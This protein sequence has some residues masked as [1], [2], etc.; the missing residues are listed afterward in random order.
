MKIK[1]KKLPSQNMAYGGRIF[2]QVAPNALPDHTDKK[3]LKVNSTLQPVPEKEANIEAER[4]ETAVIP[5]EGGLPAHYKIGGKR[6]SQGGTPLNVPE[7]TFIFSDTKSMTIRDKDLLK[8]FGETKPK[9]PADIAKKYDINEYRKTLADPDS[10]NYERDTAE[11]MI[12]K[13]N[14]LLGKLALV[15]E[16]KKGFPQGIPA[17]ALPYVAVNNIDPQMILPSPPANMG[18]GQQQAPQEMPMAKYG[19][20]Q[21][22]RIKS[23]P[24][25][26]YGVTV[27]Q[28][29]DPN[30]RFFDYD[31]AGAYTGQSLPA[32]Y[33]QPAAQTQQ[34]PP[35]KSSPS[36]QDLI[37]YDRDF[38]DEYNKLNKE[39]KIVADIPQVN[40]NTADARARNAKQKAINSENIY[41]DLDWSSDDLYQDFQRRHKWYLEQ[42]PD[43]D[44][45]NKED[46]ADFQTKYCQRASSFGMKGCHFKPSGGSGTGVDGKFGEHTWAAPGFNTPGE[47]PATQQPLP[48]A[49]EKQK[50]I[51]TEPLSGTTA[52]ETN[53]EYF[54]QDIANLATAMSA[55]IPKPKTFYQPLLFRG[56]DPAY[57]T[58]DYSPIMEAANQAITGIGAYGSRQ[59]ADASISKIQGESARQAADHNLQVS[60]TN[61][62]IYNNAEQFNAQ[63]A[64]ANSQYNAQKKEMNFDTM[65]AYKADI[66]KAKNKKRAD[67]VNMANNMLT[68]AVGAYNLNTLYPHYQISPSSGGKAIFDRGDVIKANKNANASELK[69]LDQELKDLGYTREERLEIMK[70]AAGAKYKAKD[71]SYLPDYSAMAYPS[72]GGPYPNS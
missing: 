63:I 11:D 38:W 13:Y 46:V 70:S 57:I 56:M 67:V 26:Q 27:P 48:P 71:N 8:F 61:A 2:N 32:Q 36:R 55:Q 66:I 41:G 4:G 15:Q 16:S 44:P 7:D 33:S 64:N 21:K 72:G 37:E 42:N 14:V 3:M 49:A 40:F 10:D 62:G 31:Q 28:N 22:V 23:L 5:N 35:S 51:Q 17:I 34:A 68:N 47:A 54:P 30:Y 6:H 58:P 25:A 9:T 39:G 60:N 65:E 12:A 69:Q 20:S 24:K 18:Q 59:S 19:G 52:G 53:F 50:D 29:V 1:I 43:F 45:H